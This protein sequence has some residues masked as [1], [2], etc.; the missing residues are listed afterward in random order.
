MPLLTGFLYIPAGAGFLPSTVWIVSG[1]RHQTPH[2]FLGA[3]GSTRE[4][5][6]FFMSFLLKILKTFLESAPLRGLYIYIYTDESGPR[7]ISKMSMSVM[8]LFCSHAQHLLPVGPARCLKHYMA[9][10]T[11][12]GCQ[13]TILTKRVKGVVPWILPPNPPN[14]VLEISHVPWLKRRDLGMFI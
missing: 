11:K 14:P 4:V 10:V 8:L 5:A 1:S 12:T 3:N 2:K 6:L 13:F 7:N 9:F